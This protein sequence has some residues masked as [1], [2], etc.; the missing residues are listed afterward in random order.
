M[1]GERMRKRGILCIAIMLVIV[2]GSIG[3]LGADVNETSADKDSSEKAYDCFE[4]RV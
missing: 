1:L 3:V 4:S 2:L